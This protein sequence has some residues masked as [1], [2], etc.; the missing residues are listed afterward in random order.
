M[1]VTINGRFLSHRV[2]GIERYAREVM[3]RGSQLATVAAPRNPVR[4][5]RGHLWEQTI[6][7]ARIGHDLLW[8]P[9]NTGP[10]AVAKQVV[11]IHDCA[12]RDQPEG[13]SR[14]FAAWYHWLVPKLARRVRRI[15]TDSKFSRDR[16]IE[17]C[18]IPRDKIVAIPLGVDQRFRPLTAEV[19]A[20]TRAHLG[21]PPRYVLHV[22]CQVPRKNSR[23]LLE[24]WK[25]VSREHPELCL[26]LVGA[27]DPVFRDTGLGRLP[28]SV[29]LTG[30][31]ADAYLP[32]V[33]GGAELFVFPSLYEGFGLPVLE[34]M[35][36][37]TPVLTSNATSLPEVAGNAALLVDP[38]SVESLAEGLHRLLSDSALR[39][40]LARRGLERAGS[41]TW[42]RTAEATWQVLRETESE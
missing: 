15:I 13:F 9:R 11:T 17:Y 38:R 33:Y 39:D 31:V 26:V 41:F 20:Q 10:L 3:A 2:T 32:A 21:L 8:S 19:I 25:M 12:F 35:A 5:L 40:T 30:Y 22:G 29:V 6:L 4:G 23:R 24:A 36:C 34:A 7:P 14:K 28:P 16:L 18:R 37:G 1:G 42:D 27:A